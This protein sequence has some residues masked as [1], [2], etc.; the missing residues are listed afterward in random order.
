MRQELTALC[1]D[2]GAIRRVTTYRG[3]GEASLP[4]VRPGAWYGGCAAPADG[5][6]T[7]PTCATT[8]TATNWKTRSG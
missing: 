3:I 5:R 7:T 1:C 4:T 2:C 6:P 8:R